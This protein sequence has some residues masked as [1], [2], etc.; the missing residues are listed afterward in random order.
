M[1]AAVLIFSL[2]MPGMVL[3]V[4]GEGS[5]L[6]K[7][8]TLTL[9]PSNA[10][11][12]E[13]KDGGQDGTASPS[14]AMYDED[15]FLMDG[16][17]D[18]D[19][20]YPKEEE[21]LFDGVVGSGIDGLATP[22]NALMQLEEP[23]AY[24]NPLYADVITEEDLVTPEEALELQEEEGISFRQAKSLK[25]GALRGSSAQSNLT[26]L[27]AA[28]AVVRDGM[29]NRSVS[30][31]VTVNKNV[32]PFSTHSYEECYNLIIEEALIH[33][34]DPKDPT[35]GDYLR[36]QY[37]GAWMSGSILG[38]EFTI[39]YT[40]T[41]YDTAEQENEVDE[42]VA[43]VLTEL[44]LDGKEED[45]KI[46]RIYDY[47]TSHVVYD[48][49]NLHDNEYF[50]KHTAYA[51][52][53]NGT[54]VCQGYAL[55]FYRLCLEAGVEARII[56]GTGGTS[57]NSGPHAWNIVKIGSDYYNIDSTWDAG[58]SPS[59]YSY[60]LRG[61]TEFSRDHSREDF[62]GIDYT[63]P[64][65]DTVD[66]TYAYPDSAKV[67]VTGIVLSSE[68]GTAVPGGVYRID[69]SYL[70]E[71]AFNK[72][73]TPKVTISSN[74]L[75]DL[76]YVPT[77]QYIE[78]NI[79]EG[80]SG[81]VTVK[82]TTLDE[83]VVSRTCT[84]DVI[85][86]DIV[87]VLDTASL[88]LGGDIGVNFMIN[89]PQSVTVNGSPLAVSDE[90]TFVRFTYNGKTVDAEGTCLD[91][92]AHL[93][94][95]T[96]NVA[97]KEMDDTIGLKLFYKTDGGDEVQIP[98]V[99]V[100]KNSK[101]RTISEETGYQYS[102]KAYIDAVLS[103]PDTVTQGLSDLLK[104]MRVYGQESQLYFGYN[105]S[106]AQPYDLSEVTTD[107]LASHAPDRT[108]TL[109]EGVTEHTTSLVL[110]TTTD[111]KHY[112]RLAEGHDISEYSFTIGDKVL[113]P[114][115]SGSRYY[116]RI[117]AIAAQ[118]LDKKFDLNVSAISGSGDTFTD[119]YSALSY[120]QTALRLY[121]ND[122][123]NVHL[124]NMVRALYLY[125]VAADSYAASNH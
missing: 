26:P 40:M 3:A 51:A 101:K 57:S 17:V 99:A 14:N 37:G 108:G 118:E 87:G 7:T 67:P 52:L 74:S 12:S 79:P 41:Y 15:G 82:V 114:E 42:A 49:A 121:S 56:A 78:V 28:G 69:I 30:I 53:I 86:Q 55:L 39:N 47:I 58:E 119:S 63:D 88:T 100:D 11:P 83:P 18:N 76:T 20:A 110:N 5:S 125:N 16:A 13:N 43:E 117:P 81:R 54:A 120:C 80:A 2:L 71:N 46:A 34:A 77:S 90:N 24:I 75:K 27:Q 106:A 113:Q 124:C 112:F 31:T 9:T 48:Y 35:G 93:Y 60:F 72:S 107:T 8:E 66:T 44:N 36:Y 96:Y 92:A 45:Y 73:Y 29:K 91:A 59:N 105:T 68:S 70:P 84:I 104:A 4:E 38:S 102:V 32:A 6:Q 115:Q 64:V 22:A 116:V 97:A 94:K 23:V 33:N 62:N 95:Y 1:L 89:L 21:L 109:P 122:P 111:I 10:T 19:G 65:F 61:S 25:K 103:N 50:L 98:L 85:S 123:T